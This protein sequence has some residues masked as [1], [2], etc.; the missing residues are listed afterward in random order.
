MISRDRRSRSTARVGDR[1]EARSR[2]EREATIPGLTTWAAFCDLPSCLPPG[3][4]TPRAS[5]QRR[6]SPA[7]RT[8][9][10]VT[11]SP[12]QE[13]VGLR[14]A[15]DG[16]FRRASWHMDFIYQ[17]GGIVAGPT[18]TIA[19]AFQQRARGT[20]SSS[21]PR[22]SRSSGRIHLDR[23]DLCRR[24]HVPR[25]PMVTTATPKLTIPSPSMVHYRGGRAAIDPRVYPELDEFWTDLAAAYAEEVA[26]LA[27][28]GCTLPA[29]RRH[30]PRLLERPRAARSSI[31]DQGGD[32]EHQ[33][34]T[35]HRP[36]STTRSRTEP[37]GDDD[38][39]PLVP[40]ELPVVLGGGGRLRLRGRGALQRARR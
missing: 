6:T 27:E 36:R 16:E 21:P 35:L 13:E 30:E 39:D 10:S 17:L 11:S 14:S 25:S 24:L 9:P 15:T 18:G 40:R 12:M 2:A 29:A 7:S 5:C 28:L 37:D 8:R 19:V 31:A 26:A 4:V 33:H 34:L 1:F 20:R 23:A 32:P 3:S 22:R 38:H